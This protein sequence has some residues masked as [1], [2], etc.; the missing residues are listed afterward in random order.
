MFK[1][2]KND[3]SVRDSTLK[4]LAKSEVVSKN[5]PQNQ[6]WQGWPIKN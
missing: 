4:Y 1:T 6:R 2:N 5:V 3:G